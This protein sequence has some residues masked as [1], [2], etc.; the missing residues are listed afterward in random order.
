MS[1]I[2]RFQDEHR[3]VVVAFMTLENLLKTGLY[4]WLSL[5]KI[6]NWN[7]T[8]INTSDFANRKASKIAYCCLF[9]LTAIEDNLQC[10]GYDVTTVTNIM[11]KFPDVVDIQVFGCKLLSLA[12]HGTCNLLLSHLELSS[13]K[14]IQ[15]CA[16]HRWRPPAC[17]SKCCNRQ[18]CN[19]FFNYTY[20]VM[21][22]T[23]GVFT[24]YRD[25]QLFWNER[26]ARHPLTNRMYVPLTSSDWKWSNVFYIQYL[27]INTL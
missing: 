25:Q 22:S 21:Q 19:F 26:Y 7:N 3:L 17:N 6:F 9:R 20:K 24:A 5:D 18:S 1:T 23:N 15:R 2:H 27:Y 14:H 13:L 4:Q 11:S 8:W 12:S 10:E 16:A